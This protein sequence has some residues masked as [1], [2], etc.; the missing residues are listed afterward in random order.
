MLLYRQDTSSGLRVCGSCS[1]DVGW[2]RPRGA[3]RV[4]SRG[5]I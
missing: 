5:V 1:R 2:T 3:A 4:I